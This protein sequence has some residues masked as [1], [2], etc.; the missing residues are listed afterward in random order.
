MT[1]EEVNVVEQQIECVKA[2][3]QADM[4]IYSGPIQFN[5]ADSYI[6]RI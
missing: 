4:Y 2:H 5:Y 1:N 6:K 3:L